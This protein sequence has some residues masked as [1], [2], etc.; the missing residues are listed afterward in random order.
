MIAHVA[1]PQCACIYKNKS[2]SVVPSFSLRLCTS[3]F[4]LSLGCINL[5][6]VGVSHPAN[7]S[8]LGVR[9]AGGGLGRAP[10]AMVRGARTSVSAGPEEEGPWLNHNRQTLLVLPGR[11]RHQTLQSLQNLK[12]QLRGVKSPFP[13]KHLGL[14]SLPSSICVQIGAAGKRTLN[15]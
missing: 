7:K 1:C 15:V 3:L 12:I 5:W 2:F 9:A 6:E 14:G 13:S 8:V 10:A 4:F 11:P